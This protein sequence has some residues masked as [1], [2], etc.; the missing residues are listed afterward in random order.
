[1]HN[2]DLGS[3]LDVLLSIW[4]YMVSHGFNISIGGQTFTLSFAVIMMGCFCMGV[5]IDLIHKIWWE[6]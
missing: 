2:I 1:M 3:I 6:E 5:I 4:G